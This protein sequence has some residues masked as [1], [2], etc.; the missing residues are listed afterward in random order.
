M[1]E[2]RYYLDR[3]NARDCRSTTLSRP[4]KAEWMIMPRG[5][6]NDAWAAFKLCYA[7]NDDVMKWIPLNETFPH[8]EAARAGVREYL[9]T[10]ATVYLDEHGELLS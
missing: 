2:P 5:D 1:K 6:G 9:E 8:I 10:L 7:V 4:P 3:K